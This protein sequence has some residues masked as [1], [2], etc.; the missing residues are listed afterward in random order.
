[1]ASTTDEQRRAELHAEHTPAAI[2]DR[3]DGGGRP[4]HMRDVVYGAIDGTVT[5]FAVA[6]GA[7]G[8]S[9]DGGVVLVLGL[10]NLLADGF[11]MAVSNYL[12][13]QSE[14]HHYAMLRRTEE[15]HVDEVPEGEREEVRQIYAA[16]GFTGHDLDRAVEIITADRERWIDTMMREEHGVPDALPAPLRAGLLTLLAF[17]VVGVI[18]LLPFFVEAIEASLLP[19]PILL[20]ALLTALAF[21]GTGWWKGRAVEISQRRS[22]TETM[23]LGGAAALIAFL[24]GLALR[25]VA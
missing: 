4:N 9:L 19:R 24:V 23:A 14:L 13:T 10:A 3:L 18:P 22:V 6:A 7:T 15:R 5:T 2:R 1:M 8:A 11:S 25:G 16:K 12:G 17:I 20:S 21:A